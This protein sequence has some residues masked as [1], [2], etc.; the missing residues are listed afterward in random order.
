M[1]ASWLGPRLPSALK[2]ETLSGA[3]ARRKWPPGVTRSCEI[4]PR[5][6]DL[7]LK[8]VFSALQ[9]ADW[10]FLLEGTICPFSFA[11]FYT[12][13]LMSACWFYLILSEVSCMCFTFSYSR[14]ICK[15]FFL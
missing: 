2:G 11:I 12:C 5:D 3:L 6:V 13:K 15:N 4:F 9:S 7:P 8:L 14:F 10:L 1:R